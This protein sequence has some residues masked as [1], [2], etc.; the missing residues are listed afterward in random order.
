MAICFD[1]KFVEYFTTLLFKI[2][3]FFVVN[4]LSIF[5]MRINLQVKISFDNFNFIFNFQIFKFS[6]FQIF[7]F[8]RSGR[9]EPARWSICEWTT[10]TRLRSPTDCWTCVNGCSSLWYFPSASS[11]SWY[12][13]LMI[14]WQNN[15]IRKYLKYYLFISFIYQDVYQK[16]WHDFMRLGRLDQ[17]V[18]AEAKLRFV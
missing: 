15:K 14:Y 13:W 5:F 7:N 6:N 11:F 3:C 2:F 17:E 16:F 1:F 18:L 4:W 12:E 10:I 9:C 8:N